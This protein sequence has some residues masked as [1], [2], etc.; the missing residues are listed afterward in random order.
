MNCHGDSHINNNT[1]RNQLHDRSAK[2]LYCAYFTVI[3]TLTCR[4]SSVSQSAVK[5][6]E[7]VE[8]HNSRPHNKV[9]L[10]C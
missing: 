5:Q 3:S 4:L 9:V 8:P 10:Q 2:M 7:N 6:P 1:I